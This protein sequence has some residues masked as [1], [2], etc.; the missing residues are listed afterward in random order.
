[1]SSVRAGI[2]ARLR[3][4]RRGLYV[5]WLD[6]CP[7][8]ALWLGRLDPAAFGRAAEAYVA[9][10]LAQ[11]GWRVIGR[12]AQAPGAELD[13]V[14]WDGKVLVAVEVKAARV[15]E[16]V[17]SRFR[18][19]KRLDHRRLSRQHRA[20]TQLARQLAGPCDHRVDLVELYLVAGIRRP[21]LV[22]LRDRQR[23]LR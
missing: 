8:Q 10:H 15:A 21:Q 1:M 4:L 7:A 3:K 2:T 18:P 11:A 20:L 13:I 9:E 23:P 6:Y 17:G 22:H 12:R 16:R 14:A 19:G 5:L